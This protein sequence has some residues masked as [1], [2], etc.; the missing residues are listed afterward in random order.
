[1]EVDTE[2]KEEGKKDRDKTRQAGGGVI[3]PALDGWI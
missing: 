1:M 2:K 3:R